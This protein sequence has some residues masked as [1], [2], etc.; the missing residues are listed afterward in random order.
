MKR[1]T[2]LDNFANKTAGKEPGSFDEIGVI[3]VG[4]GRCVNEDLN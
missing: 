3:G 2:L 1:S 4:K